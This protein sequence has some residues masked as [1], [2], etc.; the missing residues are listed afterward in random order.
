MFK[1]GFELEGFFQPSFNVLEPPV[2]YPHDGMAGLV[3]ART[4]GF[5]ELRG[6][7]FSLLSEL[8]KYSFVNYTKSEHTFTAD[9][10]RRLR[11]RV[12]NKT[13]CDIQN[14]Y[15]KKPRSLGNKTIASLQINIS[16]LVVKEYTN[17]EK[18][19]WF[20][21]RFSLLDVPKIVKALDVEFKDEIKQANRQQGEYCIKDDRLEYRSLPN[22]VAP[23]DILKVDKFLERIKKAVEE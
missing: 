2:S 15:G 17:S 6:S 23:L 12:V 18:N 7:Y 13:P 5:D 8:S 14:L 10:K 16:N 22:F 19:V 20:P 11:K 1:Y 21:N 4:T 3:E 9:Q